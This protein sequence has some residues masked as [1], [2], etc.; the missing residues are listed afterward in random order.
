MTN[1]KD[2]Q[3]L[4]DKVEGLDGPCHECDAMIARLT[5]VPEKFG[6]Y[7]KILP[8]TASVDA[9][10]QLVPW[11]TDV[12]GNKTEQHKWSINPAFKQPFK[13]GNIQ[14]DNLQ[15]TDKEHEGEWFFCGK[16]FGCEARSKTPALALTAAALRAHVYL[17]EN[18]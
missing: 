10:M 3:A 9:A 18:N 15:K 4:A 1:S 11:K 8:V 14:F 17:M 6:A 5:N 12:D 16:V 13:M 7:T 2:L